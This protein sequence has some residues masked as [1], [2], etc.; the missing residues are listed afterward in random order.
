MRRLPVAAAVL[1]GA[2]FICPL[3]YAASPTEQL[4]GFFGKAARILDP[5]TGEGAEA[6]LNA[7]RAIVKE[8]VDVR[9]AAQL[10][11]GSSWNAR[12]PAEREEFVP[13]FAELLERALIGGI[14]GK[15][16]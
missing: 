15:I 1:L 16:R 5:E 9:A 3:A 4:R 8:M 13:L 12:T 10:S 2:L 11:L 7:I 14:A 6:R